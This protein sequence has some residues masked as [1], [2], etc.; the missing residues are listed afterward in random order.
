M[1]IALATAIPM[2]AADACVYVPEVSPVFLDTDS[3][4][5]RCQQEVGNGSVEAG[6]GSWVGADAAALVSL[7][8]P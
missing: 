5:I 6:S 8:L 7:T 1:E 4:K 3:G 2:Q